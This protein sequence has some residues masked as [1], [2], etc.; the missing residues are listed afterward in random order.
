MVISKNSTKVARWSL[1]VLG[2]TGGNFREIGGA[3]ELCQML[4]SSKVCETSAKKYLL[5]PPKWVKFDLKEGGVVKIEEKLY[6]IF[7][8]CMFNQQI[9]YIYWR[10][11]EEV[12]NW[13]IDSRDRKE[14]M[15]QFI[16]SDADYG[17]MIRFIAFT[18]WKI[19]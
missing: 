4:W 5:N 13:K 16:V 3:Q 14:I 10:L 11:N 9:D 7:E 19:L 15:E 6:R 18:L 2:E 1:T 17:Q 8:N 12:Q